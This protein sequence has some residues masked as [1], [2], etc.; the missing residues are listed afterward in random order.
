MN[1]KQLSGSKDILIAGASQMYWSKRFL[2]RDERSKK[3][4]LIWNS[5][6]FLLNRFK[7]VF[8][9]PCQVSKA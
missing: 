8:A 3:N 4:A 7:K 2:K 9:K 6:R 5:G 1:W